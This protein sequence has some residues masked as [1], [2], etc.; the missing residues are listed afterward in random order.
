MANKSRIKAMAKELNLQTIANGQLKELAMSNLD[1]LEFVFRQ[2][3]D[4]RKRIA[5]SKVRK[6]SNLPSNE[7]DKERLNSGLRYQVEKLLGC[8]W[9]N[10]CGNLV[11][12]GEPNTGK[13]ALATYLVSNAIEKGFRAFY[14]KMDD[15]LAVLKQKEVLPKASATFNKIRNADVLI[16]D[17]ILYLDIAKENL[18]MLY[19]TIMFLNDTT[20]IVF[21]TNREISEWLAKAE[22]KYAMRLLVARAIENAEM[23]KLRKS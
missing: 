21:V 17:E 11:I 5:I 16:L 3:L 14:I 6:S 2:E 19:K 10:G 12:I 13:T 18:E 7:F 9:V 20:S 22:D 1:Y 15:L 8:D 4:S 23:V